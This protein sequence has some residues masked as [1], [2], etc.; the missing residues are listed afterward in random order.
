[1]LMAAASTAAAAELQL[2]ASRSGWRPAVVN[3]KR[4]ETVR[5]VLKT[6]DEEHCFAVDAFRIEKRIVPGRSTSLDLTP[7][8]VGSFPFYDCLDPDAGRGRIVVAD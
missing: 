1:M 4:G 3:L 2:A 5:I 7:D 6:E 8:R